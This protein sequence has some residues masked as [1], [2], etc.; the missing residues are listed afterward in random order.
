MAPTELKELKEQ[1]KD[2]LDK[3]FIRPSISIL[4]A[5]VLFVK[6]I[7]SSFRMFID[8]HLRSVY[9]QFRVRDSDILKTAFRTRIFIHSFPID[10]V[11]SE[12]GQILV[13][14]VGLG[15]VLMQ[16]GKVITYA[17]R[18]LKFQEK[19]YLTHDLE[20]AVVKELNLRQ[21]RWLEFLKDYDMIVLYHPGKAN[22]VADA[23]SR[24]SMGS[25]AHI[26]EERKELAKDVHRLARLEVCLTDT[27]DRGVIV[28]NG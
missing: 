2:L 9:H 28:Q 21:R 6:K 23:L 11:D 14:R 5:P 24:L 10:Q 16:R 15:C 7:Y 20:L 13:V 12:E 19:N 4:G 17:S 18:Q 8:Y 25:V 3:G 26:E 27:S 22:V 1:L